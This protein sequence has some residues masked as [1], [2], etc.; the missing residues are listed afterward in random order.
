M[1]R[2]PAC[3]VSLTGECLSSWIERTACFYGCDFDHWIGQ[4]SV[5]LMR[6]G[7]TT[8]DL[9]LSKTLWT[10]VG[11][12][13]GVSPARLPSVLSDTSQLLSNRARLAFCEHCWDDDV[14]SGG[15]PYIRQH[16]LKWTT[17]HCANHREFLSAKYPSLDR[18]AFFVS[19]QDIWASK[20]NWRDAF[21]LRKRAPYSGTGW[22]RPA[23]GA[24][25]IHR[26]KQLFRLLERI[27]DASDLPANEALTRALES[28]PSWRHSDHRSTQ[29]P[30]MFESMINNAFT[31][32]PGLLENR[33][34]LLRQ[35]AL[36]L[37]CFES[38]RSSASRDVRSRR[39]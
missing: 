39:K 25:H 17:V 18:Y 38:R 22:Y 32:V 24:A 21:E 9:D 30:R 33:I 36:L 27:S 11:E 26:R 19:W 5:E 29:T 23:T 2:I 15:Q 3:P 13:T 31:E 6:R 37:G 34:E 12:C 14:R 16:W 8:T 10:V 4:F 1:P 7:E 28:F 20:P 35:T